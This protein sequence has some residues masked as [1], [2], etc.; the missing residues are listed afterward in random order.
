MAAAVNYE[1]RVAGAVGSV[2]TPRLLQ[3]AQ[4]QGLSQT[5]PS[6][7]PTPPKLLLQPLTQLSLLPHCIR[8]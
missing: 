8:I 2:E 1:N 4:L 6:P 7:H 5:P 3:R